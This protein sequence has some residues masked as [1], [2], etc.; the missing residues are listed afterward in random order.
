MPQREP[1]ICLRAVDYSETSQVLQFLAR[2]SGVIS[3][4]GKGTKRPKGPAGGAIDLMAEGEL[5]FIAKKG[6][7]LG[8]LTEFAESVSRR[9]LRSQAGALNAGLY[10]L[11]LVGAALAESDPHPEVFDL[12]HNLLARLGKPGAP[13]PAVTAYFQWRLLRNV[14]LLGQMHACA[15]CGGPA[16][17]ASGR[18][19][20]YFS[21]AQGGLLCDACHPAVT[22]K[23]YADEHALA[24]LAA[25]AAA[26]AGQK[27]NLTE[28]AA[29]AVMRLLD[30]HVTYQHG[31]RLK[32]SRHVIE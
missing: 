22:E 19:R 4:M 1:A 20:V 10:A 13:V 11:E 8:V 2:E 15:G 23:L 16:A 24:G 21:S 32:M 26:E 30:Y 18:G 3:L 7:A 14:G 6:Q 9:S 31:R 27:A 12:L 29:R 25:L 5:V 28:P 17:G